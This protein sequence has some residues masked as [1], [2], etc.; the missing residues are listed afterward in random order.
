MATKLVIKIE[1]YD[2]GGY[3]HLLVDAVMLHLI[4]NMPHFVVRNPKLGEYWLI[5]EYQTGA[6]AG[7]GWTIG[8]AVTIAESNINAIGEE[9]YKDKLATVIAEFG[10]AN[11]E[12]VPFEDGRIYRDIEQEL[13]E[14][15]AIAHP[16][17]TEMY[18]TTTRN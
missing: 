1:D 14:L 9:L 12:P 7:R 3:K 2:N 13:N 15:Y 16:E 11:V 17:E 18:D 10:K 5:V 6:Y 8:S 4:C